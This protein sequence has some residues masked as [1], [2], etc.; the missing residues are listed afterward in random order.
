MTFDPGTRLGAYDIVALIGTGGMGEVYR[1]RD[2][3]LQRDVAIKVLPQQFAFDADRLAR[4]QREAQLLASLNDPNIA[5]IYGLEEVDG[6]SAL[7]LELVEGPTLADRIAH[8][9]IPINEGLPIARQIAEALRAAHEHGIIHRDLKPANVKLRPDGT[10]KVLDFGLAKAFDA[11]PSTIDASQSPT[12]T[13]PAMTAVGVILGTAAYMSPEQAKAGQADKRSDVWAFGA[14]FYEML[15]GRRAYKGEDVIDTLAMVLKGEP[16]WNALPHELSP[17]ILTLLRRCLEKD[18]RRR[19]AELS[20]VLFVLDEAA[21][22]PAAADRHAASVKRRPILPLLGAVAAAVI[23][24][25][26]TWLLKPAANPSLPLARFTITLPAD[27]QFSNAGRQLVALSPDGTHLAYVANGRLYLRAMD[28][29]EAVAIRGTEG[30]AEPTSAGRNPFFS[31]DGRWIGFWHAG[32]LKKVSIAGGVPVP[33][34]VAQPPFGASWTTNNTIFYGQGL[35]GIWRVSGD[36]GTP[37]NVIKM[38]SGQ[39]AHGP[40]VLPDGRTILFTLL[41]QYNRDAAQIVVQSLDT[42]IRRVVVENGMEARYV[43]TGHLV[44]ALGNT[45]VG[46]PF[47]A[48]TL[49]VTGQPVELVEAVARAR[50]T[51]FGSPAAAGGAVHFALSADG[52]LAYVPMDALAGVTQPRH[53]LVWVDRAGRETPLA[54]PVRSYIY[55][56]LSPDGTRVALDIR[57]LEND[58]WI[59]NLARETLMR[60]TFGPALEFYAIWT[61]DA[62]SVIF[63]SGALGRTSESRSIYRQAADGTGTAE[64]LLPRP[65]L[66]LAVTP[67]GRSLI[68]GQA[69]QQTVNA[70]GDVMLTPLQGEHRQQPL[71]QTPY[72]ELNAEPSPDGRWL[73]YESNE[74]GR[75]EVYVRPFPNVMAGRWQVSTNGGTRPLWAR[76]GEELFYESAG[77][78]MRVPVTLGS[79]FAPGTPTKLFDAPYFFGPTV[80]GRGRTYDVSAD[81]RRFLMIKEANAADAPAP[82]ARLVLVQ[83]WF[84]ELKQRV[85]VR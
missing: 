68:F 28:Q 27:Q 6:V 23:T 21:R 49:A 39:I 16:E 81:G 15:S 7:V 77:A 75:Y 9:P 62:A 54:A 72:D 8:G 4:F 26:S 1:A 31:P 45:L 52:A 83:H 30:T 33:L 53:T 65:A 80:V 29:L 64:Q 82:A 70:A 61:P 2:T 79:T 42:G 55:P 60:L 44:Y 58:I 78:L 76:N 69:Q 74:S 12:I 19:I 73:A 13:S 84:D 32:Q 71:V 47:N 22:T 18:R 10:V 59:W 85:P 51:A 17:L 3:K 66:P 43:S 25:Y 14:V 48:T 34:C 37:E 40:Q 5:A 38:D 63:S 50:D 46:V 36:G 24:G 56:R 41:N 67:D 57:D 35:E 20:T 11:V